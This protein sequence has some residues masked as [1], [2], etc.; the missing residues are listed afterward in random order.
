MAHKLAPQ[1]LNAAKIK[2]NGV[3]DENAM[4]CMRNKMS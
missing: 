1:A 3:F 2:N 4:S